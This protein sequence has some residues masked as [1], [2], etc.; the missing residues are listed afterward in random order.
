MPLYNQRQSS[1]STASNPESK[2]WAYEAGIKAAQNHLNK[3]GSTAQVEVLK[4]YPGAL[5]A[6]FKERDLPY[7]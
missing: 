5:K 4:L 6:V 3:I 2:P 7:L 1:T